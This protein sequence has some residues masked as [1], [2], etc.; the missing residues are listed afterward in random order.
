MITVQFTEVHTAYWA[1]I[2]IEQ[3]LLDDKIDAGKQKRGEKRTKLISNGGGGGL[4][5]CTKYN[6]ANV[7]VKTEF[8]TCAYAHPSLTVRSHFPYQ[9]T[10]SFRNS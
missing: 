9:E 4:S 3:T 2:S 8:K 5:H 6:E 7:K 10:V 1:Q